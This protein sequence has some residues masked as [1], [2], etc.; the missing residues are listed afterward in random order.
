M[1]F[2]GTIH[3]L[4]MYY[5]LNPKPAV[6][7]LLAKLSIF[8]HK[9][10]DLLVYDVTVAQKTEFMVILSSFSLSSTWMSSNW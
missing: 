2:C 8:V 1:C 3:L 10:S 7:C 5:P 6:Q 9:N 4:F